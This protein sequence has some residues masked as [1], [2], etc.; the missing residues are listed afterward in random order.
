ME[1]LPS[2]WKSLLE[3]ITE[4]QGCGSDILANYQDVVMAK[5][6]AHRA[7]CADISDVESSPE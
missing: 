6:W 2:A 5:S 3:G 4:E 7:W 1:Q